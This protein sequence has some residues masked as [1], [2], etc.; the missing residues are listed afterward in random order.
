MAARCDDTN[1]RA[2]TVQPGQ[3]GIVAVEEVPHPDL[4]DGAL[5]VRGKAIGVCG[6]DRGIADGAYGTPPPSEERLTVGHE[7]LGE[8]LEAP[9]GSGFAPGDLIV[10][11][12][13]RPD[14]VPCSAWAAGEW[15][16]CRNDGFGELITRP[17]PLASWTEALDR[18]PE[19][20]R[21]VAELTA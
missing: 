16:M 18:Q 8:V 15:D 2:M 6:T 7:S 3:K 14:P 11:I 10:G 5:L 17:E 12:S 4:H 1:V 19:D 20:I 13:R 21:V 9:A